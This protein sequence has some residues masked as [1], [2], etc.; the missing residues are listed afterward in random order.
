M[1]IRRLIA[2]P[3]LAAAVVLGAAACT[4]EGQ[5]TRTE[6]TA[7]GCTITF[8]RGVEAK[9]N[10]LGVDAELRAVDGDNVT[11]RVAGQDLVVPVGQTEA[12]GNTQV[13]VQEVT[14]DKVVVVLS[15]GL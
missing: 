6:C 12:S 4:I 7:S 8:D 11:L 2:T 13:R 15:T 1:N 10:V 5:G 3:V 14:A 9:A